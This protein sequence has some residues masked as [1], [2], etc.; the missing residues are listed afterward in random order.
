MREEERKEC[1]REREDRRTHHRRK[2]VP[3]DERRTLSSSDL[4]IRDYANVTFLDRLLSP[5]MDK[6]LSFYYRD[7][8]LKIYCIALLRVAVSVTKYTSFLSRL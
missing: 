2:V 3:V 1:F 4:E 5:V 7:D 6:L 8:A